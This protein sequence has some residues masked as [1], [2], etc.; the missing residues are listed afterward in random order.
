MQLASTAGELVRRS[1]RL[2]ERTAATRSAS[3]RPMLIPA[4][5]ARVG[6]G[7]LGATG[8]DDLDG[9]EERIVRH[10]RAGGDDATRE[11]DRAA[12]H[13]LRD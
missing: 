5:K 4:S 1:G 8:D 6:D 9:V 11:I 13:P 7:L 12:V 2:V 10:L 3:T